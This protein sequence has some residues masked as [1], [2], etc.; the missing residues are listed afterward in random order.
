MAKKEVS[1]QTKDLSTEEVSEVDVDDL[2]G[3]LES[4]E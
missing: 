3:D 2:F 1:Q 4:V